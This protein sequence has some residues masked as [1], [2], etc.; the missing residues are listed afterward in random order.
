MFL[1]HKTDAMIFISNIGETCNQKV[2]CDFRDEIISEYD[3]ETIDLNKFP[4]YFCKPGHYLPSGKKPTTTE[5][6]PEKC[7]P[8]KCHPRGTQLYQE[9]DIFAEPDENAEKVAPVLCNEL[10]GE[11]ACLSTTIESSEEMGC[12]HC[13]DTYW[14]NFPQGQCDHSM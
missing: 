2:D 12:D 5:E 14:D 10:T 11:C 9:T 7:E 8:C 3:P 13:A 1:N 4:V 6:V